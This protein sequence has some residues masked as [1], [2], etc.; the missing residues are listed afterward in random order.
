MADRGALASLGAGGALLALIFACGTEDAGER[1]QRSAA[2]RS[3]DGDAA[4]AAPQGRSFLDAGFA[5]DEPVLTT[6]EVRLASGELDSDAIRSGGGRP[7]G[8]G[9]LARSIDPSLLTP[10]ALANNPLVIGTEKRE[11]F[12]LPEDANP[13]DPAVYGWEKDEDGHWIISWSDLSLEG[14]DKDLLLDALVYPEEY[15]DEEVPFPDR[16]KALDGEKIALTGYMIAVTWN[17]D[18]VK[19]FMLVRDLMACCFGGSP[20][21]DEWVD[22]TMEGKGSPYIQFVPVVTRGTFHI[23]GLS[24][25]AGYATGAFRLQG[26][27]TREE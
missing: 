15:E 4:P 16:I 2:A 14:I 6:A 3:D 5:D 10:E 11:P 7:S 21:P 18:R 19:N 12:A 26:V 20:E 25:A 22:V 13:L 24:D 9:D 23:Q 8:I 27:D 17:D 1:P